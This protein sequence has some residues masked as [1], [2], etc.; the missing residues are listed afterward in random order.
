MQR[1]GREL[2]HDLLAE[3]AL[4]GCL[5]IDNATFDEITDVDL[6]KEDFYHPQYGVIFQ[7]IKE[8]AVDSK[9]FDL[10]SICA[11]L[12]D[13][14]KL[15]SIGGQSQVIE[16]IEETASSANVH[17]YAKIL[18]NKSILREIVRTS[19]RITEQGSNFVGNIEEFID[20]VSLSFLILL[21][22]QKRIQSS[23]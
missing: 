7:G 11:K 16:L 8:L 2:P 13:M 10:V 17:H 15:E 3:K 4:I 19:M 18:K 1:E 9:P 6:D 14:G 22:S 12:N 5:L 23:L 21:R 20:E